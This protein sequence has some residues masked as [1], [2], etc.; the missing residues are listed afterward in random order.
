MVRW[1]GVREEFLGLVSLRVVV[2]K[3]CFK[4]SA[5]S[6]RCPIRRAGVG[7]LGGVSVVSFYTEVGVVL[8]SVP[9]GVLGG[10]K[11]I[12]WWVRWEPPGW[13]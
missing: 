12:L 6:R 10:S 7:D 3:T 13:V 9:G 5:M 2:F 8:S 1:V 11:V 4:R